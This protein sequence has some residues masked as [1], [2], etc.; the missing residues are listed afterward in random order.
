MLEFLNRDSPESEKM[1]RS[2]QNLSQLDQWLVHRETS[3][4]FSK[5][6]N[7]NTTIYLQCQTEA[8]NPA[9][10]TCNGSSFIP[11]RPPPPAIQSINQYILS[12]L[13]LKR[14]SNPLPLSISTATKSNPSISLF[15]PSLSSN[16]LPLSSGQAIF[17]S[18]HLI[19]YSLG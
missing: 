15:P 1:G 14:L 17:K 13:P 4:L 6:Q 7:T 19:I 16:V 11:N 18:A 9:C 10:P 5:L 3:S 2:V 8:L 12:S